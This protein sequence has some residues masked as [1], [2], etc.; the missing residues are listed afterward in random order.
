MTSN[1]SYGEIMKNI[2]KVSTVFFLLAH[3]T[4]FAST[5]LAKVGPFYDDEMSIES[6]TIKRCIP[7]KKKIEFYVE[8]TSANHMPRIKFDFVK[9][10]YESNYEEV[11]SGTDYDSVRGFSIVPKAEN[12]CLVNVTLKAMDTGFNPGRQNVSNVE[13]WAN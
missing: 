7:I 8:K 12:G 9:L 3:N 11:I 4:S 13:I 1:F 2:L 6:V 10:V 5:Y